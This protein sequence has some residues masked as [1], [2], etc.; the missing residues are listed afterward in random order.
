MFGLAEIVVVLI[1]F[2]VIYFTIKSQNPILR[3]C[4]FA[5]T[6]F[7][8]LAAVTHGESTVSIMIGVVAG[9]IGL[10]MLLRFMCELIALEINKGTGEAADTPG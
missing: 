6:C 4:V 5:V 8:G 1:L 9:G 7:I 2:V 10:A 3:M